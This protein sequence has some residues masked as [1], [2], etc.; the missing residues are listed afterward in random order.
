MAEL[1]GLI[2]EEIKRQLSEFDIGMATQ[3]IEVEELTIYLT[4]TFANGAKLWFEINNPTGVATVK[5]TKIE[6]HSPAIEGWLLRDPVAF[7]AFGRLKISDIRNNMKGI[8]FSD[9]IG[10]ILKFLVCISTFGMLFKPDDMTFT[11]HDEISVTYQLT[12]H[13]TYNSQQQFFMHIKAVP[14][15]FVS[16]NCGRDETKLQNVT[17]LIEYIQRTTSVQTHMDSALSSDMFWKAIDKL[18]SLL[19]S[20]TSR[21]G[22]HRVSRVAI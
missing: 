12:T 6:S 18:T 1:C 13:P 21:R 16:I 15:G 8:Y 14:G 9:Y 2:T 19:E 11:K 7:S 20:A 10:P 5:L 22:Y 17:E 3:C 4:I